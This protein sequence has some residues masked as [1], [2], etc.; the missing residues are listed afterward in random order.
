MSCGSIPNFLAWWFCSKTKD[1]PIILHEVEK[2]QTGWTFRLLLAM[3]K[4][5]KC[6]SHHTGELQQ[7]CPTH[8]SCTFSLIH[9]YL[10]HA[11][12]QQPHHCSGGSW[13]NRRPIWLCI[14]PSPEPICICVCG[15]DFVLLLPASSYPKKRKRT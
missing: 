15:G 5:R 1:K 14:W 3:E 12:G 6:L 4:E 11:K 10:T 7:P 2:E 13:K 9:T 8:P